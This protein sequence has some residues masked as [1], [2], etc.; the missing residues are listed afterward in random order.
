[1]KYHQN[2]YHHTKQ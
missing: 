1:M 2:N